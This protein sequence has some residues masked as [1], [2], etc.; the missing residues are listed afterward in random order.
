MISTY[1]FLKNHPRILT[2]HYNCFLFVKL[3]PIH[4]ITV[5]DNSS[6]RKEIFEHVITLLGAFIRINS[7]DVYYQF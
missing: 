6:H 4:K 1:T 2:H 7:V 5:N 3:Y